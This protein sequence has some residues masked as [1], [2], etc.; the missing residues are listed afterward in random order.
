L[1]IDLNKIIDQETAGLI[2]RS[3]IKWAEHGEKSSKYFCNLEKRSNEKKNIHI[4]TNDSG[5]IISDQKDILDEL[6]SFYQTLYTSKST[7]SNKE[8]IISYLDKLNMAIFG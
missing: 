1:E 2:I 3:R 6:H 4:L 5:S 8:N 7:P